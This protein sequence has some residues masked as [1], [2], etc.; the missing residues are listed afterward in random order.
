[1]SPKITMTLLVRNEQDIISENIRL[2]HALG[3]DSFIVMD[4]LST[5]KTADIV[6]ALAQE[7]DIEYM[8]Q[9]LDNYSQGEWVTMMARR[10]ATDH[11]AN[12]VINS[13]ADEFWLPQHGDLKSYLSGRPQETGAV[14]AQRHNG[15]V[16]CPVGAPLQGSCEPGNC[17]V[18]ERVSTNNLGQPL[19]GKV[20]HRAWETVKVSQGNHAVSDMP[21]QTEVAGERLR[22]L[23]YPYRTLTHYKEKIRLGGAAYQRNTILPQSVG[24]TWRAHFKELETGTLDRFWTKLSLTSEEAEIGLLSGRLFRDERVSSFIQN[25]PPS[26]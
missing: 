8:H 19:P 10:A 2:H 21:G 13:D 24:G 15:I 1:M 12:W 16:L 20:L 11:R 7:I 25:Y 3:V 23:H 4:N 14:L 5:D 9:P 22:I 18:F 26:R 17:S 6:R